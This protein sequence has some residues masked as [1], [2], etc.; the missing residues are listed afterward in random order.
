MVLFLLGVSFGL[1]LSPPSLTSIESR[2]WQ[3]EEPAAICHISCTHGNMTASC[4]LH[5]KHCHFNICT[6]YVN[7]FIMMYK[8]IYGE[9][10]I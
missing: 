10:H 1:G 7:R 6:V 2:E 4:M 8:Q 3:R 5:Y 9:Q